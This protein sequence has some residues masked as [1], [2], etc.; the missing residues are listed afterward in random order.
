MATSDLALIKHVVMMSTIV[1]HL[2]MNVVLS[3]W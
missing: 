1:H 2:S 3:I